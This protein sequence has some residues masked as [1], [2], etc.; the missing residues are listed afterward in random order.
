MNIFEASQHTSIKLNFLLPLSL[1]SPTIRIWFMYSDASSRGAP[2]MLKGGYDVAREL[3]A[4][5]SALATE[6]LPKSW[7]VMQYNEWSVPT[8]SNRCVSIWVEM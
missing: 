4:T 5:A 8:S 1:P 2:S 3:K 6:Y 7:S